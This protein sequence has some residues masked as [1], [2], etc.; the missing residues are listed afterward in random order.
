MHKLIQTQILKVDRTE[1]WQFI[2]VPQNLDRITPP[3][4]AFQ[5]I[6]ELPKKAYPGLMLSDKS[7]LLNKPITGGRRSTVE[8]A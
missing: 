8:L 5:I 1:L 4:M 3:D 6:G 2:S 7:V